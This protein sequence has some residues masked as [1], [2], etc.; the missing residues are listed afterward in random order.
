M[1]RGTPEEWTNITSSPNIA[2]M[3]SGP[4]GT[5]VGT[6][7]MNTVMNPETNPSKLLT[8]HSIPAADF[9]YLNRV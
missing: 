7:L 5:S 4:L 6:P 9:E 1:G 8:Q 3:S 2:L